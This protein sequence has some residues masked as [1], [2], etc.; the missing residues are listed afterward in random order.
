MMNLFCCLW[1]K[2]YLRISQDGD[3]KRN[4]ADRRILHCMRIGKIMRY[5]MTKKPKNMEDEQMDNDS[6]IVINDTSSLSLCDCSARPPHTNMKNVCLKMK[7]NKKNT[8]FFPS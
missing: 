7:K 6:Y 1:L 4:A 2:I 3:N 8:M 5:R